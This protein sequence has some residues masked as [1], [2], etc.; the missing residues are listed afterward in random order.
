MSA[1]T[2][3]CSQLGGRPHAHL[4][5]H[6]PQPC[7][8]TA[9]HP[10]LAS[11][12]Q[13]GL[14]SSQP[15]FPPL[16]S[17]TAAVA[18]PTCG[19]CKGCILL[20]VCLWSWSFPVIMISRLHGRPRLF[21]GLPQLYVVFM[22]ATPSPLPGIRPPTSEPQLPAPTCPGRHADKRLRLGSGS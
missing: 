7:L 8:P 14:G 4:W 19:T 6:R 2:C 10:P 17:Q 20:S 3:P 13:A 1:V 11:G 16:R 18:H 22:A 21:C 5:S 9:L 15:A 12:T